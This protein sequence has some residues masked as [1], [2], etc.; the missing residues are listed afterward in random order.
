MLEH[1]PAEHVPRPPVTTPSPMLG[2]GHLQFEAMLNAARLSPNPNEFA[3]ICLLGLLGLRIRA[4]TGLDIDDL[5][6]EHGHRVVRVPG[7]GHHGGACAH[8]TGRGARR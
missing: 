4:A 6:E 1:S 7:K 8:L 3:L 2:L 5:G